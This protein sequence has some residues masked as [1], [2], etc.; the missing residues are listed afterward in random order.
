MPTAGGLGVKAH[1]QAFPH[2]FLPETWRL[3]RGEVAQWG[4]AVGTLSAAAPQENITTA[5]N[6]SCSHP[7]TAVGYV[8]VTHWQKF[9]RPKGTVYSVKALL[10]RDRNT[11]CPQSRRTRGVLR[12]LWHGRG[13]RGVWVRAANKSPRSQAEADSLHVRE[14]GRPTEKPGL[15]QKPRKSLKTTKLDRGATAVMSRWPRRH[16]QA[17]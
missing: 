5:N 15:G 16:R 11:R 2:V 10:A 7:D 3:G 9:T 12:V 4:R 6:C 17:P 13:G 14:I 1:R 8:L